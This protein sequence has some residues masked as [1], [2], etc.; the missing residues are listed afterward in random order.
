MLIQYGGLDC[1]FIVEHL[2]PMY[3]IISS[4]KGGYHKLPPL[5]SLSWSH[6]Y[7]SQSFLVVKDSGNYNHRGV[8]QSYP[9]SYT[10]TY[11]NSPS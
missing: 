7:M 4:D 10:V 11:R 9:S 6:L 2:S 8:V 3:L 1:D 5:V